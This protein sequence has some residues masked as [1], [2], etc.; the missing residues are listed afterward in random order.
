MTFYDQMQGE[1]DRILAETGQ[2]M[3]I[4]HYTGSVATTDYDDAQVLTQSGT[5][6]WTSGTIL[7]IKDVEGS[8]E[9]VL[10]QQGKIKTTDKKI[11]VKGN[12][13]T[14]STMKIGVGSPPSVE[15][16]I[17]PDGVKAQP[18]TGTVVYKKMFVRELPSGSLAGE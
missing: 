13:E 16:S 9:A 15:H 2:P 1:M 12:I 14:T 6:V 4:R 8:E 18:P 7:A 11:Y 3:R 17:I 10:I 5:A